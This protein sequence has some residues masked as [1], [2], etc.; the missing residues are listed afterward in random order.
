ML[1]PG[2]TMFRKHLSLSSHDVHH[3]AQALQDAPRPDQTL[4]LQLYNHS[5]G[6]AQVVKLRDVHTE[7]SCTYCCC[8]FIVV[9]SPSSSS[10]PPPPSYSPPPPRVFRSP[11][12]RP[13]PS[14]RGVW[15]ATAVTQRDVL[16]KVST[17]DVFYAQ[18]NGTPEEK[19]RTKNGQPEERSEKPIPQQ[20]GA[21]QSSGVRPTR[22]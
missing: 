5:K 1:L 19:S 21:V 16:S 8:S 2:P 20:R 7:R 9:A 6:A 17:T 10:P 12:S 4:Y 3:S 22:C 13:R 18:T 11:C 14:H 15:Q